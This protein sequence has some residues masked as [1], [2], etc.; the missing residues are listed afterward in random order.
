M[1]ASAWW[2]IP[3]GIAGLLD[4]AM[5][6]AHFGLQWEWHQVTDFGNLRSQLQWALFALNFS[7]GVLLLAVGVLVLS[8]ASRGSADIMAR[9]IVLIVGTF[10]AIHGIYVALIPMPLPPQLSWLRAPL[11]AFPATLVVLH[12]TAFAATSSDRHSPAAAT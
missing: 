9:Q 5:S 12:T 3:V 11:L 7:W 10:W 1:R 4:L 2:S 8:A 6:I